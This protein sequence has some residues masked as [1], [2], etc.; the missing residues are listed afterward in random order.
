MKF[1]GETMSQAIEQTAPPQPAR[2][3]NYVGFA[4]KVAIVTVAVALG[5][6]YV[7]DTILESVGNTVKLQPLKEKVRKAVRDEKTRV[8]LKGLLTN[9]PAVHYRVA[10]IAE[11]KGQYEAAIEEIEL[12]L[13]LL[14]LHAVD[15]VTRDKYQSRLADLER[16]QSAQAQPAPAA[17][18]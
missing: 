13:G 6:T 7:A 5:I 1:K 3:T 4:V 9:N 18:R 16:K 2:G 15:R 8:R 12:A 11:A 10:A 14:E 17:K